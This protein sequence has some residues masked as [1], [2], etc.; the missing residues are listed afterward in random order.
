[1]TTSAP[2][3]GVRAAITATAWSCASSTLAYRTSR[4]RIGANALI[5]LGI[6]LLA[7]QLGAVTVSAVP[8]EQSAVV[9]GIQNTVTDLG[10]SIG[11]AVAGGRSGSVRA[12]AI[13]WPTAAR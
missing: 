3:P 9:G 13:G 5:G 4:V 7:S 8:D 6:G 10:A 12:P 2:E 11:T 1:M